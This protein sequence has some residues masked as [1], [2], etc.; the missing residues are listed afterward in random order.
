MAG[1]DARSL[2]GPPFKDIQKKPALPTRG[3]KTAKSHIKRMLGEE[4]LPALVKEGNVAAFE[5]RKN[6]SDSSGG[7]TSWG[8]QPD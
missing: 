5:F 4:L 8:W 6:L 1:F 7:G 2:S 3:G